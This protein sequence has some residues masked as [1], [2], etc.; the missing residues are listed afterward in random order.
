MPP[1]PTQTRAPRTG[2]YV[3]T[4]RCTYIEPLLGLDNKTVFFLRRNS[5]LAGKA[6]TV[7]VLSPPKITR[8]PPWRFPPKIQSCLSK[9]RGPPI[10]NP[11]TVKLLT[12][13]GMVP[14]PYSRLAACPSSCVGPP[15]LPRFALCLQLVTLPRPCSSSLL[16]AHYSQIIRIA[17]AI[18]SGAA[19]SSPDRGRAGTSSTSTSTRRDVVADPFAWK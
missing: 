19:R 5:K 9:V 18:P 16:M 10:T 15:S 2:L 14:A 6:K 4:K 3:C 1:G 7:P 8:A 17:S 13:L 11:P 12:S